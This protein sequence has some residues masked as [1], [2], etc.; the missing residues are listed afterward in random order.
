MS[1][2]SALSK[3]KKGP[4][5]LQDSV[6]LDLGLDHRAVLGAVSDLICQASRVMCY[7]QVCFLL[8]LTLTQLRTS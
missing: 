2:K 5:T 8:P 7:T 6:D 3:F 4:K 1:N